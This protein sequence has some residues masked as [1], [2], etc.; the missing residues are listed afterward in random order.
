MGRGGEGK[1]WKRRREGRIKRR[2]EEG[3]E[4]MPSALAPA[5]SAWGPAAIYEGGGARGIG[6]EG[7]GRGEGRIKPRG[8][9]G[10]DALLSVLVAG[11]SAWA[12]AAVEGGRKCEGE[13]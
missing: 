1:E 2:G 11:G 4:A 7:E 6:R 12:P 13:T 8:E 5:G 9:E 3:G 10:G